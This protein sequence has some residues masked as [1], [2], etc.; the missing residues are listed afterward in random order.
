MPSH[1]F[2]NLPKDKQE[3]IL[4][5]SLNE[6]SK[7]PFSEVSINK[8]IKKA[9]ISRGSFYTYFADKY[10]LLQ[11]ILGMFKDKVVSFLESLNKDLNGD[12]NEISLRIHKYVFDVYQNERNKGFLLNVISYFHTHLDEEIK[13]ENNQIPLFQNFDIF[14]SLFNHKQF[15]F[16]DE[17]MIKNTVDLIVTVF[18][19]IMII[20]ALNKLNYE[21]SKRLFE[22]YLEIIRFGYME[23]IKC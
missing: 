12:I 13:R 21:D 2:L 14:Y 9:K 11:Y 22:D 1:T 16:K 23:E 19:N 7:Y 6:F 8:I 18:K 5:A 15:K 3:L 10:D 17:I 4:E 20:T